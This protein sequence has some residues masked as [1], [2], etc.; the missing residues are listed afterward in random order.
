MLEVSLLDFC[1]G[2]DVVKFHFRMDVFHPTRSNAEKIPSMYSEYT[3]T[4]DKY[5]C[6]L[7]VNKKNKGK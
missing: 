4:K 3:P 6:H 7:E 5:D 1:M 2:L